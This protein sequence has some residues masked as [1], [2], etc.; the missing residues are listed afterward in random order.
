MKKHE[1]LQV[2]RID[3]LQLPELFEGD[4]SELQAEAHLERKRFTGPA[5]E[6]KRLTG[7]EFLECEVVDWQAN[8]SD[9][10]GARFVETR[11][12]GLSAATFRAR[13]TSWHNTEIRSSRMGAAEWYDSDVRDAVLA[14]SKLGWAN[15]RASELS[16]VEIRNC[17]FD[18]L[19]L[20]DAKLHRVAFVDTSVTKLILHGA[21]AQH[22]DLRG[23]RV[24]SIEGIE[25]LRGAT[26]GEL[27]L[28]EMSELFAVHLGIQ[29][30]D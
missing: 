24:Q 14:D 6:H 27:Q 4:P 23:L 19:D 13:R 30:T 3:R 28:I 12:R 11:I 1:A 26:I 15:L 8:E 20:S 5:T 25:G 7:A 17:A 21:K 10:Q 9:L 22:F 16:D 2:P 18:E 29:V